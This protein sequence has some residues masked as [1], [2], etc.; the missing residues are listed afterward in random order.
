MTDRQTDPQTHRHTDARG[1]TICLPT[2]AGGRHNKSNQISKLQLRFI[3]LSL[4]YSLVSNSY[5]L[6][7]KLCFKCAFQVKQTAFKISSRRYTDLSTWRYHGTEED[8]STWSK[9]LG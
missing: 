5:K 6:S 1:K 2:L 7:V 9:A 8:H 4:V 3:A